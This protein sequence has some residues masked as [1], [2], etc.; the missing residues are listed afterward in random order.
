MYTQ[1]L[2]WS[3]HE[4]RPPPTPLLSYTPLL[5]LFSQRDETRGKNKKQSTP[6][7]RKVGRLPKKKEPSTTRYAMRCYVAMGADVPFQPSVIRMGLNFRMSVRISIGSAVLE[8]RAVENQNG[9]C[10]VGR[11]GGR[12]GSEGEESGGERSR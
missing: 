4:T 2:N 11:G 12:S 10:E 8:T 1:D 6:W 9:V 7:R 5:P 3:S